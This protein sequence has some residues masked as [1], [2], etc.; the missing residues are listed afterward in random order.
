MR[1]W[2]KQQIMKILWSMREATQLFIFVAVKI[3]KLFKNNAQKEITCACMYWEQILYQHKQGKYYQNQLCETVKKYIR[4]A[5]NV[6]VLN[7]LFKGFCL[8][9]QFQ[10]LPTSQNETEK[11]VTWKFKFSQYFDITV[12][13][14]CITC[15]I[16]QTCTAKK[17]LWL[18]SNLVQ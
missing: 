12:I 7:F 6:K 14:D 11:P 3:F 15:G 5:R 16:S 17:P 18:N 4:Q 2:R 9:S 1:L 10:S 8:Y 13:W